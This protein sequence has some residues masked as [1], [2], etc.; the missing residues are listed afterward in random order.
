MNVYGESFY[1]LWLC[2][3]CEVHI[4]IIELKYDWLACEVHIKIIELNM[5]E[6]VVQP[7]LWKIV[8]S[9]YSSYIN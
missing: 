6:F 9:M 2:E 3:W 1:E 4:K 5:I 7:K 8:L